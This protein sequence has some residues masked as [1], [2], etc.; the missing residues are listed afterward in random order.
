VIRLLALGLLLSACAHTTIT[1]AEALQR[2]K[3]GSYLLDVR[4]PAEFAQGHLAGARNVPVEE[5][6]GTLSSLPV[7]RS[8]EIL[9]VGARG[10]KA[11]EILRRAGFAKVQTVQ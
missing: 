3:A 7:D 11:R 2:V 10:P 9:L 4:S 5:I 6:E 8:R 1:E